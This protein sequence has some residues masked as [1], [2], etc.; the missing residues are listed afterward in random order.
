MKIT[1]ISRSNKVGQ[2][3]MLVDVKR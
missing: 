2:I 1:L 3:Q